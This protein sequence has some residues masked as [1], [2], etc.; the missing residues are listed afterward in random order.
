MNVVFLCDDEPFH[1]PSTVHEVMTRLPHHR[2][3]VVSFPGHGSFLMFTKNVSRYF[4]LYGPFG[5]PVRAMQFIILK[6]LAILRV[7]TRKPHSL[8]E[9]ARRGGGRF[10]FVNNINT[11]ESR[12]L[13]AG[14][15]PDVFFSIACPQILKLKTLEIPKL[16]VYNIHTSL[17]PRDRGM[18]PSF[19]TLMDE[20][21]NTG[22]TLHK[23]NVK[24][25]DGPILLQRRIEASIRDT[26][27]HKLIS[28][29][30]SVAVDLICEAIDRLESGDL[31][32]FPNDE[33]L[34]TSNTFPTRRDVV[35][36]RRKGGRIW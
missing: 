17:L 30:K 14:G 24:L 4:A 34:S 26:S 23:M 8:S 25:D 36:F 7:P 13:L 29:G 5:F 3:T 12:D 15:S 6:L 10:L 22:V 28:R 19:W 32:F 20:G 21:S 27:L 31:E 11:K 1:I 18:L 35:A 33:A 2:Y 9:A 16:G